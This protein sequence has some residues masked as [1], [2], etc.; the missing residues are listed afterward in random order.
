MNFIKKIFDDKVDE[1]IHLQFQKFSKGEFRNRAMIKAKNSGK[2]FNIS[3]TAEFA[4]ELVRDIAKKLGNDKTKVTGFIVST[5]DLTGQ[6]DFK[7][8]KQFMGVKQYGIDKK[9]S[10]NDIIGLLEKFP[11]AFFALS[12]KADD[13]ELKIKARA[14]KSAKPST[15]ADEKI[16]PDFCK[17]KTNDA[18]LGGSF[19][20]EKPNFK[21]AEINHTFLIESIIIPEK[22]KQE[23]D[24]SKIREMSIRK[25]KIIR[26]GEIDGQKIREEKEFEA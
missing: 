4:N 3:T 14:P 15:K 20:F 1:S 21:T 17:L 23:K 24:F 25:G 11:K 26:E 13:T 5:S 10:G 6:L 12:F 19:V 8:K 16:N 22:F 9:M 2:K 18:E 7:S